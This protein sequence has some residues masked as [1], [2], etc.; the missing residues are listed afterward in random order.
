[1]EGWKKRHK[2][3]DVENPEIREKYAVF[4]MVTNDMERIPILFV[5]D[6]AMITFRIGDKNYTVNACSG[7]PPLGTKYTTQV[8]RIIDELREMAYLVYKNAEELKK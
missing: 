8:M 2:I 6:S 7:K 3:Y 1:M 4:T 5:Y